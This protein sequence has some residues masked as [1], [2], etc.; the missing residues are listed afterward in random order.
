[1]NEDNDRE[2]R[3]GLIREDERLYLSVAGYIL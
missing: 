1:M 3:D 2:I